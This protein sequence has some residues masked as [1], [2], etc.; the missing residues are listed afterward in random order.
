MRDRHPSRFDRT[1]LELERPAILD[2]AG[3]EI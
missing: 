3:I 2:D 1:L